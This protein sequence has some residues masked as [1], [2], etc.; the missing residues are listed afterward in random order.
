M[1]TSNARSLDERA[2][3]LEMKAREVRKAIVEMVH[4]AQSGHCGGSLS[5]ADFVTAL[6][7]D[8]MDID[9]AEPRKPGRDRFVLSKGHACPV[10][11]AALALRGY[12]PTEELSTLRRNDSRLQGHPVATYL[13]GIDATSGSLG[14]GFGQ[15][16][17]MA[18]DAR[19]SG[20]K[21]TVYAV[22]GDGELNEGVV[23]ETAAQ[24]AKYRLD[25]LVAVVDR[26]NLQNDGR[27]D[28]IM[29]M[30]PIDK[31]FEAFN[32]RVLEMDGHDMRQVLST[33]EKAR[34]RSG[35]PTCVIA[36]TIKGKGVSFM[37]DKREW[38]GKPPSDEERRRAC[39]EIEGRTP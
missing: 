13:P 39:E 30:E 32:W 36:R 2:A 9:P 20:R 19:L 10:W 4:S 38:H 15:A 16:L 28:V 31:K 7:F 6:Y 18:L 8:L 34:E 29:P 25:N 21:N 22:L 35:R 17:G 26:N 37:E 11:Y 3:F 27:A 14:L 1:T 12:F 5:A 24:A 33:L 23:W